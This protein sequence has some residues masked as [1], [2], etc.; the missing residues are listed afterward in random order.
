VYGRR[1]I[2][3]SDE[4]MEGPEEN[5]PGGFWKGLT[6]VDMEEWAAESR[7]KR[8]EGAARFLKPIITALISDLPDAAERVDRLANRYPAEVIEALKKDE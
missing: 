4:F 6:P 8:V 1:D 2:E 3:L 5:C 7:R